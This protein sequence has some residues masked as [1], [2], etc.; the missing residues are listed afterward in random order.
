MKTRFTFTVTATILIGILLIP[1]CGKSS[2]T[3]TN[4]T[5]TLLDP[6][7]PGPYKA[8]Y[9]TDETKNVKFNRKL[10]LDIWYPISPDSTGSTYEYVGFIHGDAIKDKPI[11][12]AGGPY[13]LVIFS[14]GNQSLSIQNSFS[15]EY[16]ATHGYIVV[17]PTHI[18][19]SMSDYDA[20]LVQEMLVIRPADIS[21]V[22]DWASTSRFSK[23]INFDAVGMTGHSYGGYTSIAVTGVEL[24]PEKF[25]SFCSGF[26][27]PTDNWG[28]NFFGKLKEKIE[29]RINYEPRIKAV[30]SLSP[31]F[32][33]FWEKDGLAKAKTPIMIMS[34]T[35]DT[36]TPHYIDA[37]PI[38]E[39]LAVPKALVTVADGNHYS[40]TIMCDILGSGLDQCGAT[41]ADVTLVK[42]I[43]SIYS[44]VFFGI[45]LK[46]VAGYAEYLKKDTLPGF[47][48]LKVDS[49]E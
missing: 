12:T 22:I 39:D 6:E 16:L 47:P 24:F 46:K 37:L 15:C 23:N 49:A 3:S 26:A 1:G 29:P 45:H 44:T 36:T 14:H 43:V 11:Y 38:Y 20:S 25:N 34:G 42:K 27:K 17:A 41:A 2:G 35:A 9:T 19:N 28:C 33:H 7:Q 4:P 30:V 32:Y 5:Y 8:G 48:L 21:S 13:P 18:K 31:A 40:F 10:P